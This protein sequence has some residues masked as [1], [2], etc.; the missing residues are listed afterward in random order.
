MDI[1]DKIS[2]KEFQEL[3]KTGQLGVSGNRLVKQ[4]LLP[5]FEASLY[6]DKQ[7]KQSK[8]NN[9]LILEFEAYIEK[10]YNWEKEE[11]TTVE[12]VFSSLFDTKRKF[13]ADYYIPQ[14]KAIIEI[15]GGEFG[16]PVICNSCG[17]KVKDKRGKQVFTQG[18][19]HTRGFKGY[20]NDLYKSNLA[21]KNGL[22]Y[23]QFNYNQLKKHVYREFI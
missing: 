5:E 8:I 20:E 18:G 12:V 22:K 14:I 1:P 15:N 3:I 13:R 23:Y 4:D 16:N 7:Q 21:Q 11:K 10:K 19:R 2:A 17:N 9:F 6:Q